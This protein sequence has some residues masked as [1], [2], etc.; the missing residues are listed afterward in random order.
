L[1]LYARELAKRGVILAVCSKND[2]AN[3]MAP[4]EQHP[5]MI[6]KPADIACFVANWSDKAQNIREIA[7]RLN[8][9]LDSLVFVDDNPFERN[10]VRSE[11]PMV[12]V[13]EVP[14]DPGLIA[15]VLAD[16]GYFE[17]LM[18][19]DEDRE[20]TG[21]YQANIAREALQAEAADL[22]AYLRGLGM[23]LVWKRFDRI[24]LARTVQLINKTNQF[25]LTTRRY[26]EED[27]LAVMD[28][29]RAFGLQLR[30]LD[31]F[32]DREAPGRREL[33]DRY[34]A[35]ELPGS[36]AAGGRSDFDSGGARGEAAWRGA[37]DWRIST[38]TKERHG[39]GALPEARVHAAR[40]KC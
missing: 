20:R 4:F 12:A 15:A 14:E 26:T 33:A 11:L 27:V 6:L 1:Q 35:D 38:D 9:G 2:H 31:R 40:A 23:E 36:W 25:N 30:L 24:G 37:A 28:D 5:E 34:V 17:G 29:P 18:V 16:A 3:A 19:T 7:Q 10:L 32:G 22:P 8:I 39:A 13:P 21:Q